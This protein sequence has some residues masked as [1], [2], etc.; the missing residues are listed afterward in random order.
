MNDLAGR[1]AL[2]TGSTRGIGRTVAL[3]L[4]DS[5]AMVAVHGRTAPGADEVVNALRDRGRHAGTFLADLAQPGAAET[6]V[7][8]A[9][10]SLPDLDVVVLVAGAG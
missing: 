2:V 3:Q 6:L 8:E 5:G 10:R 9:T 1:T 4:A 7:A